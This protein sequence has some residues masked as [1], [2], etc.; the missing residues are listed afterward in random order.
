MNWN[1]WQKRILRC[2]SGFALVVAASSSEA[3]V[4]PRQMSVMWRIAVPESYWI[5][6]AAI[7]PDG[8]RI[9][10]TRCADE[11]QTLSGT[12]TTGSG[13][14]V[15]YAI[16][17]P[18]GLLKAQIDTWKRHKKRNPWFGTPEIM[19]VEPG[20]SKP[21][22]IGY[23]YA[24]EFVD[25]GKALIYSRY[26]QP[27]KNRHYFTLRRIMTVNLQSGR[28]ESGPPDTPLF[29]RSYP[30]PGGS[31][32]KWYWDAGTKHGKEVVN[33]AL[34]QC[35]P[36]S[37][38]GVRILNLQKG[39]WVYEVFETPAGAVAL[40]AHDNRASGG[41]PYTYRYE[42]R[43][44]G[45]GGRTLFAYSRS[46]DAEAYRLP[47][48]KLL[49]SDAHT[50]VPLGPNSTSSLTKVNTHWIKLDPAT[51]A[52]KPIPWTNEPVEM[53]YRGGL[54]LSPSGKLVVVWRDIEKQGVDRTRVTMYQ[55]GGHRPLAMWDCP[56]SVNSLTWTPDGSGLVV[57]T[58]PGEWDAMHD[59]RHPS[60][61]IFL[62]LH[63]TGP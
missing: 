7:S 18:K 20:R 26:V 35:S 50:V 58:V 55:F 42:I 3:E 12:A 43:S 47:D 19:L 22:R 28:S 24:A 57:T 39:S 40:L 36:G 5:I 46:S 49:L 54:A 62:R 63:R 15:T 11:P 48:G 51:G 17:D 41:Q 14:T 9:V 1:G 6:P 30:P 52:Q 34:Y 13:G 33:V 53:R 4:L 44:L 31:F 38:R 21:R 61:I 45:K 8:R 16:S 23:G 59:T 27:T 32:R 29:S 2:A 37:N 25:D 10:F 60:E 56:A